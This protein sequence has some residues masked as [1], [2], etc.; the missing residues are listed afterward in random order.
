MMQQA[1][2]MGDLVVQMENDLIK[3]IE[4]TAF[5]PG[6]K[7][8]IKVAF[9]DLIPKEACHNLLA[10]IKKFFDSKGIDAIFYPSDVCEI[11]AVEIK[12]KENG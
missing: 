2:V 10:F 11:E 1:F 3:V 9:K 4:A 7:Y 12:E 8:L 5:E 6:K